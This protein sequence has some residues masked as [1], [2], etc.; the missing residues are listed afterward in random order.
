MG[1]AQGARAGLKL[2][3]ET[4]Y[5]TKPTTG[6]IELQMTGGTLSGRQTLL[7]DTRLGGRDPAAP[8]LDAEDVDGDITVKMCAR[9]I[10]VWL[11]AALGSPVTTGTGAERTHT[12]TSGSWDMPSFSLQIG[13]PD[14][15][16]YRLY[17]G[18]RVDRL[19]WTQ[20]RAGQFDVTV[21]IVAQREVVESTDQSGTAGS[22]YAGLLLGQVQ[23]AITRAGSAL[24]NVVSADLSYSNGLDRVEGIG[25]SGRLLG[26]DPGR[27]SCTGRLVS[28]FADMTL[29][30]AALD[31]TPS[32]IALSVSQS[33]AVGLTATMGACYLS[34]PALP[35][36]GPGGVQADFEYQAARG[37]SPAAML[38]VI[39]KNDVA[40][41][42]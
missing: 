36:T 5:G 37:G 42:T 28:R 26:V 17:T 38:Q 32:V 6:W 16:A 30:D 10:G 11:R 35:V 23:G 40:A 12:F 25:Q 4:T 13:H 9:Q 41:Y 1:R 19:A 14:V 21:G 31:G 27:T 29:Y 18:C 24:G 3:F 8:M 39:L 15:P 20:Q 7:E 33:A 22:V 34:R 2:A